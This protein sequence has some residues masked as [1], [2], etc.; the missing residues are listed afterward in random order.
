MNTTRFQR[1]LDLHQQGQISQAQAIYQDILKIQPRHADSLHLLGVTY[2]QT[3]HLERGANLI[4]EALKIDPNLAEAHNNLGSTLRALQRHDEALISYDRTL[5]LRPDYAEAHN[6]RGFILRELK[7]L[8]EAL[9]SYDRALAL[10]PEYAEAHFNQGVAFLDLKRPDDALTRFDRALAFNPAYVEAHINRGNILRNLRRLDEA[11]SSYD[12]ALALRPESADAHYNRGNAL[13]DLQRF[14]EALLSH[15]RAIALK[16]AYVEAH[17]NRG[18]ALWNLKRPEEALVSY[19]RA[20]TLR[21]EYAEACLSKSMALLLTGNFEQGWRLYEWRKLTKNSRINK[22]IFTQSL[23][24]GKESLEGKTILLH[25]EQGLGDSLQFARY[26][27]L[28]SRLGARVILEYDRPLIAIFQGLEG[29][30]ALIEKGQP[31]PE[32]DYQCPLPSLPLA[33]NTRL[34]TIPSPT[35]YLTNQPEALKRWS[36]RLGEK[37]HPRIGLVWSGSTLHNNDHNRS[38][39][40]TEML[41]HLP[42]DYDYVSLQKDVREIDQI[43]LEQSSIKHFGNELNDFTDTA[44]L[45]TLMDL[46][47]SIDTSVVHLSGALGKP[48]WVLLPYAPDWRWLLDREDSPWYSSVRLF[49]QPKHSD[50]ASVLKR[51]HNELLSQFGGRHV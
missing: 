14:N 49:R 13:I 6:N 3:G 19:D 27:P 4:A 5:A 30:S 40:L 10:R 21:P 43:T 20:I 12:R 24:L 46:I 18:I 34:D 25:T 15:E 50:W 32:F 9:S 2:V 23:W 28:V 42:P 41:R 26:A 35:P 36:A 29:I 1:A 8:D 47:I 39:T 22:R 33:L 17:H 37:T 44:A 45:C 16:P 31:L 7:R 51:I 11:L 38:M 48:T